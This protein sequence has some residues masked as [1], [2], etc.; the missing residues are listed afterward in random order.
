MKSM[1]ASGV[2]A[3]VNGGV[4]DLD[5]D[6]D[7]DDDPLGCRLH[8]GGRDEVAQVMDAEAGAEELD[9]K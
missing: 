2:A 3:G 7:D 1:K 8:E 5:D 9:A 6:G 4:D